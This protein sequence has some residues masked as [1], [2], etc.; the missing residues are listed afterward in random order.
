MA[1]H[2]ELYGDSLVRCLDDIRQ[3]IASDKHRTELETVL[4]HHMYGAAVAC[5]HT[6]FCGTILRRFLKYRCL[7]RRGLRQ[8]RSLFGHA[9]QSAVSSRTG[10][11]A[12]DGG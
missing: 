9:C 10:I 5:V 2:L 12:A 6:L 4:S 1:F 11:S 3:F 7:V 8:R